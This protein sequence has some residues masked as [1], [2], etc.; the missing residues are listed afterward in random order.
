MNHQST[1][2]KGTAMIYRILLAIVGVL[3]GGW[4]VFD[5]IHVLLRGK[6]FGPEKPG[7]W[8]AIVRAVG[9]DP[10]KLGPIFIAMGVMWLTLLI[11]TQCGLRW[12][13][14][15]ALIVAAGSLWYLPLGTALSAL[16]ILLLMAVRSHVLR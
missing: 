9:L 15:G 1:L 6:Y 11:A 12:G 5:G 3:A 10:F 7:P 2:L 4:M 13:W 16:Y 8:S 14:W